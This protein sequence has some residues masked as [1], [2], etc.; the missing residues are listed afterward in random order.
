MPVTCEIDAESGI[1]HTAIQGRVRTQELVT[2]LEA[3][4][5]RPDFRSGLNGIVDL[6]EGG[7][8]DLHTREVK[9]L[10]DLMD[11]H[12]DQIGPSRTAIVVSTDVD[13][14]LARMYQAYA[15]STSIETNIF[16]DLEDAR[17]WLATSGNKP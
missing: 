6:R 5:R 7:V 13:Y 11:R 16:R 1:V 15:E 8:A 10:V 9:W 3:V 4:I 12:R 14:G 17:R 2:A